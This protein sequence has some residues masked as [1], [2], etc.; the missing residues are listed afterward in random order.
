MERVHIKHQKSARIIRRVNTIQS[1]GGLP[2]TGQY[3]SYAFGD[4]GY[5]QKGYP[6]GGGQRFIDNGDGTVIDLVTGLMW[7]KDPGQIPGFYDRM[8]WYDAINAC[9][10]LEF[11]GWDDWRLPNINELMSIIDH[12]RYNP[13]FDTTFFT[14][15]YDMGTPYWSST[16]N[17]SW[18]DGAW[19]VYIYDGYKTC[20]GKPWDM[21]FVRPVRGGQS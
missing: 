12:S 10:N 4:D 11:A 9:E 21:C 6:I 1:N 5:Y 19:A 20:W 3:S 7:V 14:P 16:S 2:K 15:P 8:Y 13:A 17:A 18:Y